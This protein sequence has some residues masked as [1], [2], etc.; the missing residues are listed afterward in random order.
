MQKLQEGNRN[1]LT[2]ALGYALEGQLW[3]EVALFEP[4]KSLNIAFDGT[5]P[6]SKGATQRMRRVRDVRSAPSSRHRLS[7]C[8]LCAAWFANRSTLQR[9][10]ACV[11][12]SCLR[13]VLLYIASLCKSVGVLFGLLIS[14]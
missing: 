1:R 3:R 7:R 6:M 10:F 14:A 2:S 9:L 4:K 13:A 8:A 12:F 11:A 5:S